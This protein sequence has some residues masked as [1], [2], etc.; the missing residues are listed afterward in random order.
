[1]G[2]YRNKV[3]IRSAKAKGNRLTNLLRTALLESF[4][5]LEPEDIKVALS[6]EQGEDLK[7]SPAARKVIPYSFE[8][9]N[10]QK[11]KI[12]EWIKQAEE[13]S[14]G[15]DPVVVFTRN[16]ESSYAILRLVDFI[17]LISDGKNLVLSASAGAMEQAGDTDNSGSSGC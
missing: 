7:L 16:R 13:N 11:A 4:P 8:C 1:M 9:K 2:V 14:N 10:H 6:S 17:K 12:W 15:Y 3:N 5:S